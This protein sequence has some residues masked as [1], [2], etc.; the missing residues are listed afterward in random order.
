MTISQKSCAP[1]TLKS[2]VYTFTDLY[3][4]SIDLDEFLVTFP[5]ASTEAIL[6]FKQ[7]A[8]LKSAIK[9][10]IET[11]QATNSASTA[12]LNT[13]R[14]IVGWIVGYLV[15][16]ISPAGCVV[17]RN[18][19]SSPEVDPVDVV[20]VQKPC[21]GGILMS[22]EQSGIYSYALV[23]QFNLK[24]DIAPIQSAKPTNSEMPKKSI[25]ICIKGKV[26][27]KVTAI[28]PKCPVG[29]KKK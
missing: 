8:L 7:I 19:R 16:G 17:G 2:N 4:S 22:Y 25:I 14:P 15:V 20:I 27:K 23:T 13:L 26:T 6:N 24:E 9:S 29:F 12:K 11:I 28:K 1:Y 21:S 3:V 10:N 18:P 5:K